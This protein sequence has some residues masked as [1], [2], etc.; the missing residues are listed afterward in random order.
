[1]THP[2]GGLLSG[3]PDAMLAYT[4]VRTNPPTEQLS[5]CGGLEQCATFVAEN[6]KALDYLKI[7]M[8]DVNTR[9]DEFEYAARQGGQQYLV[10]NEV[11]R[12]SIE[13]VLN[14]TPTPRPVEG[15]GA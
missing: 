7:F 15:Q 1:M 3:Q 10:A 13:G 6:T 11:N 2:G 8:T 12:I 14:P 5:G 4:L 9:F